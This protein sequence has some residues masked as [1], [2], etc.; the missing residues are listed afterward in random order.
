LVGGKLLA[1]GTFQVLLAQI[2]KRQPV[3]WINLQHI[4]EHLLEILINLIIFDILNMLIDL[5]LI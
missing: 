2:F 3:G 1:D 5:I 4:D